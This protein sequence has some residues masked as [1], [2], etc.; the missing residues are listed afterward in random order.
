MV[1][2]DFATHYELNYFDF[3]IE[4]NEVIFLKKYSSYFST[5]HLKPG[6]KIDSD[7]VIY[8]VYPEDNIIYDNDVLIFENHGYEIDSN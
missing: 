5:K 8:D 1:Y 7:L 4:D 2:E 6:I 3:L